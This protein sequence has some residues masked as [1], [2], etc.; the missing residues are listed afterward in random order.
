MLEA[1]NA[2]G[3]AAEAVTGFFADDW[4]GHAVSEWPGPERYEGRPGLAALLGEWNANFEGFRFELLDQVGA[5]DRVVSRLRMVGTSRR[6]GVEVG[7]V[8][9]GVDSVHDG[10]IAET[11]W[12]LSE[13]DALAAVGRHEWR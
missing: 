7:T 11:H 5:G 13:A 4:V 3:W 9:Y 6:Q 1:G 2:S 12:F 8:L 10:R